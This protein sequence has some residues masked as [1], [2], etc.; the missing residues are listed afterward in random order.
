MICQLT[1]ACIY[2]FVEHIEL[3]GDES[4]FDSVLKPSLAVHPA[5]LAAS[6][7]T[8]PA[9]CFN[10]ISQSIHFSDV[11]S[12]DLDIVEFGGE[13]SPLNSVPSPQL[14]S[15]PCRSSGLVQS[16]SQN[17]QHSPAVDSQLCHCT[18]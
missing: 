12:A 4:P 14:R 6:P 10:M 11:S 2:L 15:L 16:R 5:A 9:N 1:S 17:F 18:C 7:E 8:E 13:I 3:E